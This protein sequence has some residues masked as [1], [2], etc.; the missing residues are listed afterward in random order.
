MMEGNQ[1]YISKELTHFIGRKLANDIERYEVLK[2]ILKKGLLTHD[3]NSAPK[4]QGM[5]SFGLHVNGSADFSKNEMYSPTI[6]CFCDI[7]INDLS[8]HI[9]KYSCFGLAF[10]KEFIANKG[11]I[12]VFYIP[13]GAVSRIFDYQ[14]MSK[15]FNMKI[16]DYHNL[17]N[18]LDIAVAEELPPIIQT[19]FNQNPNIIRDLRWFFDYSIFSFIKLFDHNLNDE[20]PDNYYFER[21]WRVIG[22]VNFRI[23]NLKRVLIPESFSKQFREDYPDYY[24]QVTFTD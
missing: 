22:D 11:G 19:F 14:D 15:C 9:R 20:N 3:P 12:P 4:I 10:S 6:V 21:E 13:R 23:D 5:D 16:K 24:G 1:R 18:Y 8:I 7:P 17:F 2:N